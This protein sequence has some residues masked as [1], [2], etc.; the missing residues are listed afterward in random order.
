MRIPVAYLKTFQGPATGIVVERERLDKFG[1]PLLGAT[2][3]PKLGLSAK[4]YGRVVFEGLKGGLDFLKDDENIGSQPFMRW[5]DRFLYAMEAVNRAEAATGEVKGHY[6]NVTAGTMEE[7]Y[8]RAEFAKEL[9]SVIVMIDLVIGYTAIQSMAKWARANDMILHLHRAGHSTYTRQKNHG[10][11]FRV[12]CKWMRMA[13]VDHIH[14]GTVVGKL[15]G[16]PQMIKGYYDTLRENRTPASLETGLFFDQDWASLRKVMPVA[17]GGIHAG[18]MHQLL[19]YLGEDCVMQFGGGTIGHPDGIQAGATA[20]RVA[21]ETMI[22]ARNEGRDYLHEGPEILARAARSC[23]PLK[24][25][26]D[27]WKDVTFDYAATDT[28]DYVAT[29]TPSL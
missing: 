18:Q 16:D 2:V 17:S 7:M 14:A 22:K 27:L 21:L 11:S 24:V 20:N 8:E 3:K 9:G 23:K 25:A 29:P 1:R 26:L 4:N 19:H 10:I 15:E 5:R 28:P 13:G 12:I 6:L